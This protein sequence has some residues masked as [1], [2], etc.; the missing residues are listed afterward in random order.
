[1]LLED[2]SVRDVDVAISSWYILALRSGEKFS[3]GASVGIAGNA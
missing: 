1:M 3:A 2:W